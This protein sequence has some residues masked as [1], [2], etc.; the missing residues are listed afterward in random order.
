MSN[1]SIAARIPA[2][3][4][5]TTS[6]SCFASTAWKLY[7]LL[8]AEP[9]ERLAAQVPVTVNDIHSALNESEVAEEVVVTSLEEIQTAVGRARAD[10]T[11][12][13]IAGGRHAMGG[14]QFCA[15]GM[16]LDTRGLD[17]VLGFDPEQGVIELEAGIQWPAL[18]EYLQETQVGAEPQ[19]GIAQKQT[20]ADRLSIGGGGAPHPPR[21]RAGVKTPVSP[22]PVF[23]PPPRPG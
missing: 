7:E 12:V 15:G 11:A 17:A 2:S 21:G 6:T 19:W 16:L 9:G 20:G 14:Q 10:G 13:A 3:P 23:C 4:A 22:P 5:P 8:R 1:A 18:I